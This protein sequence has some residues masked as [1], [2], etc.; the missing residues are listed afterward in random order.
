MK[1]MK[2]IS[3]AT[4]LLLAA[5]GLATS[6]AS[7]QTPERAVR[8]VTFE[9]PVAAGSWGGIVRAGPGMDY[10]R[11]ASLREGEAVTLLANTHIERDGY[12]WFLIRFR[13]NQLGF[14]WGG[15]LCRKDIPVAGVYETCTRAP[16]APVRRGG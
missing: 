15:I 10:D 1:P 9:R 13:G 4:G 8:D 3:I 5:T 6:V 14:Q 12:P 2:R 11:V 7:A 16:R